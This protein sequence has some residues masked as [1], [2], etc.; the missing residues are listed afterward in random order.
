MVGPKRVC[1]ELYPFCSLATA[2]ASG[3]MTICS[4]AVLFRS[5]GGPSGN[6]HKPQAGR[7]YAHV[8]VLETVDMPPSAV[9]IHASN[10]PYMMCCKWRCCCDRTFLSRDKVSAS[11]VLAAAARVVEAALPVF[12]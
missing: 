1:I 9:T 7:C 3:W 11:H 12:T 4:H 6:G 8:V 2:A 5:N 10:A